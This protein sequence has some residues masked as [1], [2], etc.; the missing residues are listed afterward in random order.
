MTTEAPMTLTDAR[1]RALDAALAQAL[2]AP[3]M[4][5]GFRTQLN[6]ALTHATAAEGAAR[7]RLEQ[8]RCER[9][10]EFESG[11]A[12]LRLRAL[13]TLIGGAIAAGA[14]V[15]P[16]LPWFEAGFGPNAT[17]VLAAV[18]T[19]AGL[20]IG[21]VSWMRHLGFANPLELI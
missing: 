10:A 18:G 15:A 20:A 4:P 8:E 17:L 14:A 9:L 2:R 1:E 13:G 3:P 11:Y 16:P 12:Q 6:A 7:L 21:T 19:L 5:A